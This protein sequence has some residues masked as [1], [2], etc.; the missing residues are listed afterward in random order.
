MEAGDESINFGHRI[1]KSERC[2]DSAL[3]AQRRHQRLS[4]MVAG[5]NGNAK[6]IE[7]HTRVVM[8]SITNQ[9]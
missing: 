2:T 9:E 1:V 8:V 5:T 6:L 7:Q 4:T 3:N